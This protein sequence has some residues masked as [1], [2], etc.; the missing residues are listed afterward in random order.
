M[1]K[2]LILL[3][4]KDIDRSYSLHLGSYVLAVTIESLRSSKKASEVEDKTGR[5][6]AKLNILFEI[7]SQDDSVNCI[8]EETYS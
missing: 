2:D 4:I 5:L 7:S 8:T 3:D 1:S 6:D